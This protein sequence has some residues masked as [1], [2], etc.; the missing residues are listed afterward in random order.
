MG[1]NTTFS[2]EEALNIVFELLLQVN[3]DSLGM[4]SI[5]QSTGVPRQSIYR[6]WGSKSGLL[7]AA[8]LSGCEY[9]AEK[10]LITLCSFVIPSESIKEKQVSRAITEVYKLLSRAMPSE[11]IENQLGKIILNRLRRNK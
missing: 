4:D 7:S 8:I 1:R 6:T 9:A 5:I 2:E 10:D 11:E 3:P